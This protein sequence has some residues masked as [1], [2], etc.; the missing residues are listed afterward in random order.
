MTIQR[1]VGDLLAA[2]VEALV[3]PVNTVGVMG[4]GLALRF[5][6]AFP[7]AFASY[8]RACA[9]GEVTIGKMHVVE[10]T[11]SPRLIVHFPT[12]QHW[13]HPSKLEYVR[14]GLVDLIRVIR[15]REIQSIAVPALGCGNGGLEWR[16]VRSL[17]VEAFE[18]LPEVRVALFEP[19]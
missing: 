8:P 10:R 3:N 17:I 6:K 2:D 12:K 16:L 19:S 15:T 5:K 14:E 1:G 4:K 13:R 18:A 9:A 11:G 7:D